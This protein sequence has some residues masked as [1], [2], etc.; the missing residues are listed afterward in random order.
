LF[1]IDYIFDSNNSSSRFFI[2]F[3][4]NYVNTSNDK[5]IAKLTRITLEEYLKILAQYG[6]INGW[7]EGWFKSREDCQKACDHLNEVY[8]P[9]I[10]LLGTNI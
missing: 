3:K 5:T 1:K 9:I 10:K 7:N 6:S 2:I 4:S 8:L